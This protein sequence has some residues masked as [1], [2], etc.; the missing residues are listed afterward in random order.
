VTDLERSRPSK[1]ILGAAS[2]R[3][4]LAAKLLRPEYFVPTL[5]AA[6]AVLNLYC[7]FPG[8]LNGDSAGQYQ[9]A[10]SGHLNDWQPP[11]MA[12]MWIL[13]RPIA[14]GAWPLFVLNTA[15]FWLGCGLIAKALV[16][17]G[18]ARLAYVTLFGA[19]SPLFLFFNRQII[20]DVGLASALLAAFGITFF[21]R[22]QR[23]PLPKPV[24]PPL[25]AILVY[26]TLVRTNAVFAV[27]PLVL[28]ACGVRPSTTKSLRWMLACF[29]L[30]VAVIPISILTKRSILGAADSGGMQRLQI[31]DIVGVGFRSGD[32]REIN[33]AAGFVP[34]PLSRC[35]TPVLW[36]TLLYSQCGNL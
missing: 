33:E 27:P 36:D 13:M 12:S 30:S 18:H 4:T 22:V 20:T 2:P 7:W 3:R 17:V 9:Q 28:Y 35:Y 11:I 21:F 26:G 25:V 10:V 23:R 16:E 19:S 34:R 31:Y 8:A 1:S 5:A 32:H 14:N 15:L 29:L 24:W 6:L